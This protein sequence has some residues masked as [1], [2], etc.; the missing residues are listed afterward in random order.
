MHGEDK[1]CVRFF[2]QETWKAGTTSR[3]ERKWE[4]KVE[5]DLQEMWC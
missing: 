4:D 3:Y 1:K 2:I 5:L